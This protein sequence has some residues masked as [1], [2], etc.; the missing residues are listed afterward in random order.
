MTFEQILHALMGPQG[1][2]FALG[3][4]IGGTGGWGFAQRTVVRLANERISSLEARVEH[5]EE[6]L[7]RRTDQLI[8]AKS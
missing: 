6:Q 1:G 5:L 8:E 4:I 2:L 7:S 3:L